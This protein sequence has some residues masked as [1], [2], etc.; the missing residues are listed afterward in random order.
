ML[1]YCTCPDVFPLCQMFLEFGV[2][3]HHF[4]FVA[5]LFGLSTAPQVFTKVWAPIL[6]LL[7]IQ[8][9]PILGYLDDLLLKAIHLSRGA[10]RISHDAHSKEVWLDP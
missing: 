2:V 7:R 4:K 10:Q 3:N 1:T 5:L 9:M 6:G 8:G